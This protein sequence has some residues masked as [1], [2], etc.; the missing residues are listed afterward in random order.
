[1][2]L[3]CSSSPVRLLGSR[4]WRG[5][6]KKSIGSSTVTNSGLS[7]QLGKGIE[8]KMGIRG[9]KTRTTAAKGDQV[10]N[11]ILAS[12]RQSYSGECESGPHQLRDSQL[13]TPSSDMGVGEEVELRRPV[14]RICLALP[15]N[16]KEGG[17]RGRERKGRARQSAAT[18]RTEAAHL[19]LGIEN[20]SHE[21]KRGQTAARKW[22]SRGAQS[23]GAVK[24]GRLRS[25]KRRKNNTQDGVLMARLRASLSTAQGSSM[26][27]DAGECTGGNIVEYHRNRTDDGKHRSVQNGKNMLMDGIGDQDESGRVDERCRDGDGNGNS[28]SDEYDVERLCYDEERGGTEEASTVASGATNSGGGRG[29]RKYPRTAGVAEPYYPQRHLVIEAA[30]GD[31]KSLQILQSM[32]NFDI[33][34]MLRK[35]TGIDY[36]RHKLSKLHLMTRLFKVIACKRLKKARKKG[37]GIVDGG[38]EEGEEDDE[39]EAEGGGS[40]LG[41]EPATS[42]GGSGS[43]KL[44]FLGGQPL[45]ASVNGETNG[46]MGKPQRSKG[47]GIGNGDGLR[48]SHSIGDFKVGE[49]PELRGAA[50]MVESAFGAQKTARKSSARIPAAGVRGSQGLRGRGGELGRGGLCVCR[51][52]VCGEV[53]G[54]GDTYCRWCSCVLCHRFE[55]EKE[56]P[57]LWVQCTGI[58]A[59]GSRC[60]AYCHIECALSRN[61]A[62]VVM[63]DLEDGVRMPLDGQY[64]CLEC[65]CVTGLLG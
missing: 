18:K 39:E 43:S 45:S 31:S 23:Q 10:S 22:N 33:C 49:G 27:D 13:T 60:K 25:Q 19:D 1:M 20:A 2:T 47:R 9:R 30:G 41:V 16:G 64:K 26:A 35:E 36:I 50:T 55:G 63:V 54:K 65:G 37:L 8:E 61:M 59:N 4:V 62:G 17:G 34:E 5:N 46:G 11:N 3:L 51:N 29:K 7:P 24:Q 58:S 48:G 57:G 40:G 52:V 21:K 53:L 6:E 42:S 32:T 15:G 14:K 12:G 38:G 56:E 44:D 28:S